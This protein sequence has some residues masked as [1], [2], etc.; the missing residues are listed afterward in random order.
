MIMMIYHGAEKVT[1]R[2]LKMIEELIPEKLFNVFK[3][4]QLAFKDVL[5]RIELVTDVKKIVSDGELD[6]YLKQPTYDAE[7]L[8]WKDTP[9]EETVKHLNEVKKLIS[10]LINFS[11]ENIKE[12]LWDY[13]SEEGRGSVLW[14]LRYSLSGRDKSPDPFL[15]ASVIGVEETLNRIDYAIEVLK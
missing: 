14:P 1:R 12:I 6:F 15:I 10:P 8:L 9:K 7:N 5:E 3:N 13:A 11:A 4:H 2:I